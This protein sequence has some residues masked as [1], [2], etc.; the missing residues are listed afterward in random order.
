MDAGS[1]MAKSAALDIDQMKTRIGDT[2]RLFK[3][4]LPCFDDLGGP[5]DGGASKE[6]RISAL[7]AQ[8]VTLEVALADQCSSETNEV[9]APCPPTFAHISNVHACAPVDARV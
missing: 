5:D 9:F 3:L 4:V 1:G 7:V 6:S 2:E 8:F